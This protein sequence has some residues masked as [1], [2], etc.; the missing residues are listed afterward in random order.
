MSYTFFPASKVLI[1]TNSD[2][3]PY[4]LEKIRNAKKNIDATIFI[5]NMRLFF[6]KEKLVKNLLNELIYAK[7]RGID[8]R[9]IVGRSKGTAEIDIQDRIAHRYLQ[10]NGVPVKFVNS[11]DD[12]S[13]HSKYVIVDDTLVIV[14]SHN[15]SPDAFSESK[16]D[17]V[18]IYSRD[19][20]IKFKKEFERIWGTGLEEIE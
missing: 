13:L 15:W 20:A 3:Y 9:I 12:Y 8:L 17:S 16:E 19:V 18:A 2:Y 1:L 6:D 14:G 4:L 10:R 7:W 5:I 11:P